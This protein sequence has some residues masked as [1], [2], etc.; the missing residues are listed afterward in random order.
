[1]KVWC[2]SCRRRVIWIFSPPNPADFSCNNCGHAWRKEPDEREGRLG[3]H[4]GEWTDRE[5][6]SF[7][8]EILGVCGGGED[9]VQQQLRRMESGEKDWRFYKGSKVFTAWRES[10]QQKGL[11]DRLICTKDLTGMNGLSWWVGCAILN[12]NWHEFYQRAK[13]VKKGDKPAG[14]IFLYEV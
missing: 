7:E 2:P 12:P 10:E 11:S 6:E 14:P 3:M 5:V 1:M 4:I 8:K 9:S 13:G